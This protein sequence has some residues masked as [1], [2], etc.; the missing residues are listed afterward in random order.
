MSGEGIRIGVSACLLGHRVRYDGGHKRDNFVADTFGAHVEWVSVCPE[1]GIGLGTPRESIRLQ[2]SVD[3][4][5][6]VAPKSGRDLTAEM[7]AFAAT[8]TERLA[9]ANLSGYIL[10]SRSPTCGAFRV[11][12]YAETGSISTAGRGLF[13]EALIKHMPLLPVEEEGRLNDLPLRENFIERVFAYHRWRELRESTPRPADLVAFHTRHKL[14]LMSHG[15]DGYGQ[16]GRLVANMR[17]RPFNALL[18]EYG[19]AFICALQKRATARKHAHVLY[20]ALGY[21]KREISALD[22][23]E[24]VALI[25]QYRIEQVPLVVPLT[26]LRHHINR[27]DVHDWLSQQ[28]YFSPYPPELMLRNHV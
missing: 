24:L 27:C 6:L 4:P 7:Q 14:Q 2:G 8:E 13:A 17:G 12:V 1:V 25:E 5:R 9:T 23:E 16:C 20:H 15:R 26:L 22:K 11:K 10:K 28:I 3:A 21:L 19:A 18:D